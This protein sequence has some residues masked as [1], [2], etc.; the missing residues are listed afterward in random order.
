MWLELPSFPMLPNTAFTT[1]L[2][3]HTGGDP[4]SAWIAVIHVDDVAVVSSGSSAFY[5]I[6]S[7]VVVEEGGNQVKM[8]AT[9]R[10][11]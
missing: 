3:T 5:D 10:I 9:R 2:F 4:L 6:T 8:V 11:G 1:S 7:N